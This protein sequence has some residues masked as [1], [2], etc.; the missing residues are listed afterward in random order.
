MVGAAVRG[1]GRGT[2]KVRG[3]GGISP[4]TPTH[5]VAKGPLPPPPTHTMSPKR[6]LETLVVEMEPRGKIFGATRKN[7]DPFLRV[8]SWDWSGDVP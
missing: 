7:F 4:P 3:K 1:R 2:G 6:W 5:A 8:L